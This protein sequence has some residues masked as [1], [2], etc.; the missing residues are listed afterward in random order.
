MRFCGNCGT[1]LPEP[2]QPAVPD[3]T[4]ERLGVMV[5]SDLLERF[6]QAGLEAR[7][8]RRNV[9]ILFVDLSG[10][11][12]LAEQIDNESLFELIQKFI[13]LLVN[14]VYKYEGMVDKLTGDGLMALFG[15][16][17]AHENNAERAIHSAMEMVAGVRHLGQELKSGLDPKAV[18]YISDLS[19]HIGLNAG[20]VI[21]GGV[22]ADNLMNYT[23]IGDVVNLAR[24]LE[25]SAGPGSILVSESVFKPN[26]PLFDFETLHPLSLKGIGQPVPAY[27]VIGPKAQPGSVRGLEGLHSP[28]IGRETELEQVVGVV[29]RLIDQK[30]GH[31]IITIGEAGMGKSRLTAELKARIAG[32]PLTVLEGHSLTYRKSIAYWI[33]Q[34]LLRNDLGVSLDTPVAETRILLAERAAS[35]LGERAPALLPYLEQLLLGEPS[36][37]AAAERIHYLDARQLRQLIFVSVRDILVGIA[38]QGPLLLILEDF[39]WAD[40]AS[41]ELMLFL[42]DSVRQVPLVIDVISRPFEG[43]GLNAIQERSRQRLVDYFTVAQLQALPPEQSEQ[44]LYSLLAIPELPGALRQL[45]IQRSA[46]L[47]FYLEEILRML[48]ENNIIY[49]AGEN[50]KMTPGADFTTLGVPDTLQGL[51]LT[52][53]DRLTMLQRRVLQTA[54]VIGQQFSVRVLLAVLH[55][56]DETSAQE[57][58]AILAE[59]DFILSQPVE[60]DRSYLFKHVLV[61]DAIYRTLLNRDRK[62]LH[63]QVAHVIESLYSDRLESQVELLANHYLKSFMPDRA[64]HYLIRAGNKVAGEYANMQARAYFQQALELLSDVHAAPEQLY[65][66]YMGLG[67]VLMIQG[68]YPQARQYYQTAMEAAGSF[69]APQG[70]LERSILQRKIAATYERQGNYDPSLAF[71]NTAQE[72]LAILPAPS[73]GED[74]LILSDMGWIYFRLGALDKAEP[75]L[76]KALALAESISQY[77]VIASIYNRLGGIYFQKEQLDQASGYTLQSL[78]LRERIGDIAGSAR[79][80]NNLGLLYWKTGAWDLALESFNRSFKLHANLGDVEGM[81]DLHTNMGLLQL[82]RGKLEDARFHLQESLVTAQ[83]IGHM[84]HIGRAYMHLS[85]LHILVEDWNAALENSNY[86]LACFKSIGVQDHLVEVYTNTGLAWLGLGNLDLAQKWGQDALDLYAE[87]VKENSPAQSEDQG[88]AIRL[89]G[90]TCQFK[91][92]YARA[93]ELLNQS[94][95][96]FASIGNEIERGRSLSALAMLAVIQGD[97]EGASARLAEARQVFQKMDAHLDLE[98]LE[99]MADI[100]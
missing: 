52:R 45:I 30:R 13:R 68:E 70:G 65:Q 21:V 17:I 85:H 3:A 46:G 56:M 11:T 35:V 49:R 90:R 81:V 69:Q 71:L 27:R 14:I 86:S 75:L 97:F 44:L 93:S 94:E 72:G 40:E 59:R 99:R 51:I 79:T 9:T 31:L 91:G 89:L 48:I 61:S 80:C 96:L 100:L 84:Y 60:V 33:F 34:D 43:S 16:P 95:R 19:V 12:T 53:F 77:D 10:F 47:P 4:P 64:L 1:R 74:A 54:T 41:I 5:G 25:E 7:G 8:Q 24:R 83:Q 28:M 82:D 26:R 58:L 73:P 38:R 66:L 6:R 87:L 37:P 2:V 15:A 98:R 50:W 36:D 20:S 39:H 67:D 29:Q 22:G 76:Q 92:E 18:P 63:G 88:R 32:L 55:T 78:N 57:A 62:E 23:A 42:M